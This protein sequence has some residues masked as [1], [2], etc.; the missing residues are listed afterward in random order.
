MPFPLPNGRYLTISCDEGIIHFGLR[1]SHPFSVCREE[2]PKITSLAAAILRNG[3]NVQ[4]LVPLVGVFVLLS[5][6]AQVATVKNVRPLPPSVPAVSG[7]RP[8]SARDEKRS[9]D[10]ALSQDLDVAAK[11]WAALKRDPGNAQSRELYNYSVGRVV[12]LLQ[13]TWKLQNAEAVTIGTGSSAYH[14]TR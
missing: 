7:T 6:C 12:S 9:P 4:R 14:L 11:A 10:V 3:L 5:A 13:G 8:A 2:V 1:K